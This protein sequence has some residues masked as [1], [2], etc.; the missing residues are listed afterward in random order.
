MLYKCVGNIDNKKVFIK[1]GTKLRNEFSVL[2]PVS[3]VIAYEIISR[4][5]IK[6]AKNK[7]NKM[8]L[9]NIKNEVVVN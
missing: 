9:P 7:L 5:N 4:F 3:E 6:C 2:E 8:K 1:T